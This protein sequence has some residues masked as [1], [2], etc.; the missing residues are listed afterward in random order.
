MYQLPDMKYPKLKDPGT[1]AAEMGYDAIKA[2]GHGDSGSYTVILN[3][4]KVIF[5]K[6]GSI[7]GN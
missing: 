4:T 7:Y 2:D 5:C 3:R 6:G 1:L